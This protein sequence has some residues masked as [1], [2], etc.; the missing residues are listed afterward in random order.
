MRMTKCSRRASV[1]QQCLQVLDARP[2]SRAVEAI[3]ADETAATR[4]GREPVR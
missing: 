4:R 2:T 3:R 1:G